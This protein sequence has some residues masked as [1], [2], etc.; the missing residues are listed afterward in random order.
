MVQ[1]YINNHILFKA[2][3]DSQAIVV[4]ACGEKVIG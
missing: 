1:H 4:D 2:L 3:R